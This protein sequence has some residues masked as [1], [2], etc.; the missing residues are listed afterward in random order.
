MTLTT[1]H[2]IKIDKDPWETLKMLKRRSKWG[3]MNDFINND[4]L[5]PYVEGAELEY[6]IVAEERVRSI[7]IRLNTV[8]QALIDIINANMEAGAEKLD[9]HKIYKPEESE[10]T[11]SIHDLNSELLQTY[12]LSELLA[13]AAEYGI[14]GATEAEIIANLKEMQDGSD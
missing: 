5:L 8:E 11:A 10:P 3:S 6:P 4:I 12:S 14:P 13:V 7:E 9:I 1:S 2:I